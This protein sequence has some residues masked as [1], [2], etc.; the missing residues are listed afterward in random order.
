MQ[1]L[2][3]LVLSVGVF[4][5]NGMSQ[6]APAADFVVEAG[7]LLNDRVGDSL[8]AGEAARSTVKALVDAIKSEDANLLLRLIDHTEDDKEHV[9]EIIGAWRNVKITVQSTKLS[10]ENIIAVVMFVIG[11]EKGTGK[12]TLVKNIDSPTGWIIA[13]FPDKISPV[14]I[15][16]MMTGNKMI[17]NTIN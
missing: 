5:G 15:R 10:D 2:I 8:E 1:S 11:N 12:I 6:P 7:E 9:V 3:L 13:Q 14:K 17:N 16:K 4:V